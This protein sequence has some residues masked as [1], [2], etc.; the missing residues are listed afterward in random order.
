M[1]LLMEVILHQL[2][3]SFSHYLQG[4][5]NPRWLAGFL[6]STAALSNLEETNVE[7]R[8]VFPAETS[9]TCIQDD[10]E[11]RQFA[12]VPCWVWALEL[13]KLGPEL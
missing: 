2:I 8:S 7:E 1:I 9:K 4:F 5:I 3:V 11:T 10:S 12:N 6:P 13:K